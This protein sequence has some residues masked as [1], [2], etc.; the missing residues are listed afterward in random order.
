MY[1]IGYEFP[2]CAEC[3]QGSRQYDQAMALIAQSSV[4]DTH[5]DEAEYRKVF[6]GVM[7]NMPAVA[8]Q[9]VTSPIA[10]RK[11]LRALGMQRPD[12]GFLEDLNLALIDARA[13]D[14]AVD[15]VLGKLFCALYYK[16][17]GKILPAGS[18]LFK[19][20]VTNQTRY[21]PE[22]YW[23]MHFTMLDKVP[24]LVAGGRSI[25]DQFDY[26]WGTDPDG[27]FGIRFHMRRGLFGV[28][29]GPVQFGEIDG[30]PAEFLLQRN[31]GR[32]RL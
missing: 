9:A 22:P 18:L 21:D 30:D 17:V 3:N 29:L 26:R 27:R 20:R 23:W 4:D 10:I 19:M 32:K 7:N 12:S 6:G 11:A 16:H 14:E 31:H 2:A 15:P 1:P 28:V 5:A 24:T 13:F 25:A 8:P